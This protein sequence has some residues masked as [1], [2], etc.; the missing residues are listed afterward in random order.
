MSPRSVQYNGRLRTMQMLD[1]DKSESLVYDVK[2]NRLYEANL[3]RSD[4]EDE[5]TL[6]DEQTGEKIFLTRVLS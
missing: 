5:F 2:N 4:N 6:L 1:I 3:D